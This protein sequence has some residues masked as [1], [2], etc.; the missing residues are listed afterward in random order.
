MH[1][2]STRVLGAISR[3]LFAVVFAIS[4]VVSNAAGL[5]AV[6]T[7]DT[8]QLPPSP[9]IAGPLLPDSAGSNS[10]DG[11]ITASLM[12][13]GEWAN[14]G[15]G[16]MV[17]AAGVSPTPT[18]RAAHS[19][20][21]TSA[22]F[23]P[24]NTAP[25]TLLNLPEDEILALAKAYLTGTRR[26][27]AA[28]APTGSSQGRESCGLY[29]E[30]VIRAAI[31]APQISAETKRQL[32][33][34]LLASMP[35]LEK[36]YDSSS[37]PA[38]THFVIKYTL[39]GGAQHNPDGV[40]VPPDQ[41][42]DG[43]PDYI[44]ELAGYA[45][46]SY[47]VES[48]TTF[49]RFPAP[50]DPMI[51]IRVFDKG[52]SAGGGIV[53]GATYKEGDQTVIDI[54][55]A[56][57]SPRTT[58]AHEL[59]H[60]I[61][62]VMDPQDDAPWVDEEWWI[63][64]GT[65]QWI[66]DAV[67]DQDNDYT[68]WASFFLENPNQ[69]LVA[70]ANRYA[71]VLFWKY[72]GEHYGTD[73]EGNPGYSEHAHPFKPGWDDNG[74]DFIR[75]LWTAC[76]VA[77]GFEALNIVLGG[78][79]SFFDLAFTNWLR[80]NYTKDI[81]DPFA[82]GFGDYLE[83]ALYQYLGGRLPII[84]S[85]N[86]NTPVQ[87][88][89][90]SVVSWGANFI[91]IVLNRSVGAVTIDLDG[92]DDFVWDRFGDLQILYIRDSDGDGDMDSVPF[93]SV[94]GAM[95]GNN[96][97]LE[98]T[99]NDNYQ[100]VV[101]IIAGAKDGGGYTLRVST[102]PETVPPQTIGSNQSS[103]L[104]TNIVVQFSESLNQDTLTAGNISVVGTSSGSHSGSYSF[105]TSTYELTIDPA[106]NFT[107]GETVN[108]TI[109]TGIRDLAGNALAAPYTFS[110]TVESAPTPPAAVVLVTATL[111]PESVRAGQSFA[112][113][114]QVTV[115]GEP[116]AAPVT[117]EIVGQGI[118]RPTTSLASGSYSLTGIPAP[119]TAGSYTVKVT[120]SPSSGVGS[121]TRT[122]AVSA[123]AQAGSQVSIKDFAVTGN[124]EPG[125]PVRFT[126]WAYN[127]GSTNVQASLR[128]E[129]RAPNGTLTGPPYT[130]P[131]I[132]LAPTEAYPNTTQWL[133]TLL[134]T[135]GEYI[136]TARLVDGSGNTISDENPADNQLSLAV[137]VGETPDIKHYR[138][139]GMLSES[140]GNTKT[141]TIQSTFR[142]A[143]ELVGT[144][145]GDPGCT[146]SIYQGASR[147]IGSHW[148]DVGEEDTFS[149]DTVFFRVDDTYGA[150]CYWTMGEYTSAANLI[151][152]PSNP[153][154]VKAGSVATLRVEGDSRIENID[155]LYGD[156]AE[157]V[158][159]NWDPSATTLNSPTRSIWELDLT[160]PPD[161]TRT[162]FEFFVSADRQVTPV[163]Y[164]MEKVLVQVKAPDDVGIS[165]LSPDG[166]SFN[167]GDPVAINATVYNNA[168]Y[169]EAAV[170]VSL[171]ITGPGGY[172]RSDGITVTNLAVGGVATANFTWPTAG[173]AGG[174]YTINVATDLANDPLTDNDSL[175]SVV[176]LVQPPLLSVAGSTAQSSYGQNLPLTLIAVVTEPPAAPV[177]GALVYAVI[178]G[179][180]TSEARVLT[181]NSGAQRYETTVSYANLGAYQY[182]ISAAKAG[183]RSGQMATPGA[184]SITNAPP[185]TWITTASVGEG[186]SINQTSATFNWSGR[187]SATP[188]AN[189]L[190]SYR[191]DAQAWSANG[192]A[193]TVTLSGLGQGGHTF[194]VR[195]YDGTEADGTPAQRA[196]TVD[197][198]APVFDAAPTANLSQVANGATLTITVDLS[199][200]AALSAGL[201]AI[202][203]FF[204]PE[205]LS[206]QE[207]TPASHIYR[208]WYTLAAGNSRADGTY[209]I[210]V[211]A[212]D[213]AGN[214]ASSSVSVRL[215]NKTP[216]VTAALPS[217]SQEAVG[218]V[219][220]VL[221]SEPMHQASVQEAFSIL[222][223]AGGAFSWPDARTLLFTP[224]AGLAN[225]T[226]YTVN[227]GSGAQD[228]AGK[229]LTP[230]QW[231]FSTESAG[232]RLVHTPIT[233][234]SVGDAIPVTAAISTV[235]PPLA[236]GLSYRISGA[237]A[238]T[239]MPMILTSA[240]VYLATI[241]GSAATV[242]GVD[243]Y[244]RAQDAQRTVTSP[245]AGSHHITVVGPP[246]AAPTGLAIPHISAQ[247]IDLTWT[248][249][250][251]DESDFPIERSPDGA[252]G[253]AEIGAAPA[254][255]TSYSDTSV[256]CGATYYYRVKAHRHSDDRFSTP[257]NVAGTAT[258]ACANHLTYTL[259]GSMLGETAGTRFGSRVGAVGDLNHDGYQDWA[260]NAPLYI[261]STGRLY[262]YWGGPSLD[263]T[264]D[265]TITGSATG[266]GMAQ[267]F[268]AIG[269][270]NSDGID[271]LFV[272]RYSSSYTNG[273]GYIYFG[274]SPFNT[275]PDVTM[276]GVGAQDQFAMEGSSVCNMGDISG[277]G[278]PDLLIGVPASLYEGSDEGKV[279]IFN[280]GPAMDNIADASFL[281]A[282]TTGDEF[283]TAIY[284]G[285][286]I[287]GDGRRDA[288]IESY[289]ARSGSIH[290]YLGGALWNTTRD[291]LIDELTSTA[292]T[293]LGYGYNAMTAADVNGDGYDDLIIG[294]PIGAAS[295]AQRRAFVYYGGATFNTVAD[296]TWLGTATGNF[297][298]SMEA[299]GDLNG[300]G[301]A[302]VAVG[303]R[304]GAGSV[305]LFGGGNPPAASPYQTLVGDASGD[306]FGMVGS[307]D[308]NGDG[309][310]EL[311]VGAGT[312]D[313]AG[314]DAGK[315]YMYVSVPAATSAP[316][317]AFS[318]AP[319]T[320]AAPLAVQLTDLSTGTITS[321]LWSFGD[322]ITS[323]LAS[324]AHTYA[325]AG[326]YTVSLQVSGPG[327]LDTLTRSSYITVTALPPVAA[328][329]ATP[330]TGTAPLAVQFTDLSTGAI[331]SR[332]WTFGDGVTSTLTSPAHTYATAGV[333]T[334]ALQV[335]GPG[336]IDTLTRTNY[337]TA[338][339]P[340]PVASFSA[341]P[342]S[343]VEPLNV[344]FTDS[345]SGAITSRHWWFGDGS[346]VVVDAG[347]AISKTYAVYGVYTVTLE[348]TGPGGTDSMTRPS[349]ITV[350][351]L[352][353]STGFDATPR[354][355]T[356]PL[357]VQF[358][359]NSTGR[360]SSYLW[361][362]GDGITSTEASPL[363]RYTTP[364]SFTVTLTLDG[365]GG[366]D[367]LTRSGFITV[368][369]IYEQRVRVGGAAYTDRSGN[370]WA[371]DQAFATGGWGYVGGIIS[372]T[373]A[374]IAN[375][376]DDPLFRKERSWTA[377]ATPGYRFTVP[378][379]AY[380]VTL[381]FSENS[382]DEAGS[383]R[384]HVRAEGVR[385]LTNYDIWAVA[386]DKNT[387]ITA[388]LQTAVIDGELTL[389]F[390]RIAGNPKV[391]AI[392]VRWIGP[393]EIRVNAGG[394]KRSDSL[395]QSW[396][397]DKAY[398][399]GG[400]GY[401]NPLLPSGVLTTTQPIS[402]TNDDVL[403]QDAR[404]GMSTYKFA[405]PNGVYSVTLR[406]AELQYNRAGRRSFDI[407]LNGTT[408]PGPLEI[409]QE[410]GGKFYA[411]DKTYT[412]TVTKKVLN[413]VFVSRIGLPAVSAIEVKQQ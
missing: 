17:P 247:R 118:Q 84:A 99:P 193:K 292:E 18:P 383:R 251:T 31:V 132:T 122:L 5:Q 53:G 47:T 303:D 336:G 138:L 347:G 276:I 350:T 128:Y 15:M 131:L 139:S 101:I 286:D 181:Y 85:P 237:A 304:S 294:A 198:V 287:N 86:G 141:F 124:V 123:S 215:E 297:G 119:A 367:T 183:Y 340:P 334:V 182:T 363:H 337:I 282:N 320:G 241:P 157:H 239:D 386:G 64:D 207:I 150:Y 250:S 379:G 290:V 227:V 125:K 398:A 146:V 173:L 171:L 289:D 100:Q 14:T 137:S 395:G 375:T 34:L 411:L 226:T 116:D 45:E 107:Y 230:Y 22:R 65:A 12:T 261:S 23:A 140:E 212:Q 370:V 266:A 220:R 209:V 7:L 160:I 199:E 204:T 378:N 262:I 56:A 275:T 349:Y 317:A 307:G 135:S 76:T 174:N 163:Q 168:G 305:F 21:K 216:Q 308:F 325:A 256:A 159:G 311:L 91:R 257:S 388:T 300:D 180:S 341:Q 208:L 172:R 72:L 270:I 231:T 120:A 10:R 38:L 147:L 201:L 55:N 277:D 372:S 203:S 355:G 51:E 291:F 152:S 191:L 41:D 240:D 324:P 70:F 63:I 200:A 13:A 384:F 400:W 314:T 392:W 35:V 87:T 89:A 81:G 195:A 134:S 342:T 190:Y 318:A 389:D 265:I 274:G 299:L 32:L 213:A 59:F 271:D 243:Y 46:N 356:G 280:G 302:E 410:S 49:L 110:F 394:A 149:L 19:D 293:F 267:G 399:A 253:W 351:A 151:I 154:V 412:V 223:A 108:V 405:V 387:A 333:Y 97:H 192:S 404:A 92:D 252:N 90:G 117:V 407:K 126:A 236:A 283:G 136:A 202:D 20:T 95:T 229:A 309:S 88:S 279:Q 354:S 365:P 362:F 345:S 50:S 225:D 249:N 409:W 248:R 115:N 373:T 185:D 371:A 1:H 60:A 218:V 338:L 284:C 94:D 68:S 2:T 346:N 48:G 331:T 188:A 272:N 16:A 178:S 77:D 75:A 69:S 9:E 33:D 327:G 36:T 406:F 352:P 165:A 359:D 111:N 224:T 28:P 329:D 335:G 301:A 319:L 114:G 98:I 169:A 127:S 210:P 391:N 238:F 161:E 322:G 184:F 326:A 103:S 288:A 196:F 74:A 176:T 260:I 403:Y 164:F 133:P 357:S 397:A 43:H 121:T 109:G 381:L 24:T 374:P 401:V 228:L 177:A 255:A 369:S 377:T 396:L 217:G 80:T 155:V 298:A 102:T 259:A 162:T 130:G 368:T 278:H 321:R 353:P 30:S 78:H 73:G 366:S 205:A 281:R 37:D 27:P 67:Y 385:K 187:D 26:G 66:E 332:L 364:G 79:S 246:P 142:V 382:Y 258:P 402:I 358:A 71:S 269:D 4:P 52:T 285:A 360:V 40:E 61:Q 222:P 167:A 113:S 175:S 328:F 145:Y 194:Y 206:V 315:A 105:N 221:F 57:D 234:A 323:T 313:A 166:G 153:V 390:M 106:T 211:S 112:V 339:I 170:P 179:P 310:P 393:Y 245:S 143:V 244:I 96:N 361:D 197:S 242:A 82:E 316:E 330:I 42:G 232:L 6:R 344:R 219:I 312:N 39:E 148:Y 189:L 83:D 44:E 380:E 11:V 295:S 25:D 273:A 144:S 263:F 158:Q 268:R 8:G 58:M 296:V 235:F 29:E 408:V 413:I 343:G 93:A 62:M 214:N 306:G 104:D 233:A 156:D 376:D 264:P 348:V 254:G 54:D 3:L 186:A 129:L